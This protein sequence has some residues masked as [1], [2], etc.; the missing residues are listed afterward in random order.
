M[1][2]SRN[3]LSV[4][5]GKSKSMLIN[6]NK[7]NNESLTVYMNGEEIQQINDTKY[8]GVYLDENINWLSSFRKITCESYV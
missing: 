1:S 7:K 5:A 6:N 2:N 8:L 3:K 4:I